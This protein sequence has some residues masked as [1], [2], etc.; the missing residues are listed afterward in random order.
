[1]SIAKESYQLIGK[2]ENNSNRYGYA[3]IQFQRHSIFRMTRSISL[4]YNMK[5]FSFVSLQ[6]SVS[7]GL[8][9][10]V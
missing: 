7:T 5:A 10:I 1:M 8:Q 2:I 3:I 6:L 9:L 4:A